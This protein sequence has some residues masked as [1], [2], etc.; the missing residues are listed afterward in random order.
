MSFS[1]KLIHTPRP[2]DGPVSIT[3][4]Y[5]VDRSGGRELMNILRQVRLIHLRNGAYSWQLHEDLGRPNTFRVE[6]A[7]PSWKE[8]LLAQERLT[9]SDQE[10]IRMAEKLHVGPVLPETRFFLCVNRELHTHRH[11]KEIEG[12]TS[13][14]PMSEILATEG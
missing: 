7:V 3:I 1:H 8:Y 10:I 14:G 6:M 12:A 4:E 9:K 13:V 5:Q 11:S 2:H